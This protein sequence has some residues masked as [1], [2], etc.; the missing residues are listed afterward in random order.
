MLDRERQS[1]N[2]TARVQL[3]VVELGVASTNGR[4][5]LL[6]TPWSPCDGILQGAR[7]V[8]CLQRVGVFTSALVFPLDATPIASRARVADGR[9]PKRR[10][11]SLTSKDLARRGRPTGGEALVGQRAPRCRAVEREGDQPRDDGQRCLA[12]SR[13]AREI[14]RASSRAARRSAADAS[15]SVASSRAARRPS[16]GLAREQSSGEKLNRARMA[17]STSSRA[18]RINCA[19]MPAT[20]W[21]SARRA[22]RHEHVRWTTRGVRYQT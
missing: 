18:A 21:H 16:D 2:S 3:G 10:V 19:M 17:W 11:F 4:P 22:R 12:S 14:N 9:P 6:G 5:C 13:A 15:D 20:P 1:G 8:G 7:R